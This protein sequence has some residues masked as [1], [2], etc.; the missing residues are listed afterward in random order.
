MIASTGPENLVDGAVPTVEGASIAVISYKLPTR[1]TRQETL[2]LSNDLTEIPRVIVAFESFCSRH[3][4]AE[5]AVQ[6]VNVALDEI[7]TNVVSYAFQD[8]AAHEICVELDAHEQ[9]LVINVKDDGRPFD[10]LKT[11][12]PDLSGKIEDRAVG[13]LGIHFVRSIMDDV[14]YRRVDGW[15]VISLEKATTLGTQK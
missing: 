9:R 6:G 1:Q 13:G 8:G 15:N 10:P 5:A 11:A 4:I 3:G 14:R 2:S 12:T 7:L